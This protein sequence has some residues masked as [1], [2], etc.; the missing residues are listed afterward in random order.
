VALYKKNNTQGIMEIRLFV[1]RS[2]VFYRIFD[3]RIFC[4]GKIKLSITTTF[5]E[6]MDMF[7]DKNGK[8][9]RIVVM[10]VRFFFFN[11]CTTTTSVVSGYQYVVEHVGS[12]GIVHARSTA[13]WLADEE[14]DIDIPSPTSK[15]GA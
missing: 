14:D 5:T 6:K 8:P 13:G 9:T 4:L 15:L 11:H 1:E 3:K 2:S 7:C 10:A 12:G